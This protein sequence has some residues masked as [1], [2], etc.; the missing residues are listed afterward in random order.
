MG[1][2][3]VSRTILDPGV[4]L[5]RRFVAQLPGKPE[6]PLDAS[7][8]RPRPNSVGQFKLTNLREILKSCGVT[9]N[10]WCFSI[11]LPTLLRSV[12]T[13][14]QRNLTSKNRCYSSDVRNC[15]WMENSMCLSLLNFDREE[16]P[17][18]FFDR[19]RYFRASCNISL[20]Q[21]LS[22]MV[23]WQRCLDSAVTIKRESMAG[24]I[25]AH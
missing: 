25:V 9:Q 8:V 5:A 17:N 11:T 10:S 24:C 4:G 6:K 16:T 7:F 23:T 13:R 12:W 15:W 2:G 19:L 22:G 18:S 14:K 20:R 1:S 3:S 21:N